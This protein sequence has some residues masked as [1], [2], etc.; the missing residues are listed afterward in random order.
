MTGETRPLSLPPLIQAA[1]QSL[2]GTT[3]QGGASHGEIFKIALAASNGGE[4][5]VA[6]FDGT[7]GANPYAGLVQATDGNLYGTASNGRTNGKGTV[8]KLTADG[9]ATLHSFNSTDGANP[10]GGL[11]Q[12][13]DG[14]LYGTTLK[15]GPSFYGTV[16]Q[17]TL[18]GVLTTLHS[19]DSTDGANPNGGLVHGANGSFYGATSAGGVHGKGAVFKLS[20]GLG[21]FVMTLPTSGA[22][23][24]AVTILGLDLRDATSVTFNGTAAA[25]TVVLSSEITTTVPAG[26]TS[27]TVQVTG[28]S[29]TLLSNVP[30]RV[31]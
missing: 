29:G 10:Y 8:F 5:T 24:A 9:L 7:N 4:T 13:T 27:G 20:V 16:F 21:P 18:G 1:D 31:R 14:N 26:A 2:Y 30:F 17:I 6:T 15:G 3:V 23:G 11:I 12:A 25:F 22:A 28:P 19:F